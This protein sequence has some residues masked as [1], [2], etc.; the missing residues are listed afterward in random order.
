VRDLLCEVLIGPSGDQI[1][2]LLFAPGSDAR[3]RLDLRVIG[4]PI[5]TAVPSGR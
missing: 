3:E 1:L 4:T 5:L 2:V